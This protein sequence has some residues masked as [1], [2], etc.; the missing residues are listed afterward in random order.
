MKKL[1]FLLVSVLILAC[2]T[3]K[4]QMETVRDLAVK[5]I[6]TQLQLPEGTKFNDANLIVTEKASAIEEM[7]ATYVVKVAI[8]SQ[9]EHGIEIVKNHILEYV[10]IGK[11]GLSPTD[12]EL[13]SFD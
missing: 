10:K 12:Y 11:S 6:I 5:D 7:A 9:D 3:E 1:L 4:R 13:I 2:S 8:K